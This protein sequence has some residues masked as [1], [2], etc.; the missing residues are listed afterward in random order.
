MECIVIIVVI[1]ITCI[2]CRQSKTDGL[3]K[4]RRLAMYHVDVLHQSAHQ[5]TLAVLGEVKNL[6][7]Q[8]AKLAIIALGDLFASLKKSMDP[9]SA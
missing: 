6:R 7:S 8:V 5:V 4:I 1:T 2:S 9:V 3:N